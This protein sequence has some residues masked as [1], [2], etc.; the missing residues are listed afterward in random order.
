LTTIV[1]GILVVDL[2]EFNNG[3]VNW[4]KRFSNVEIMIDVELGIPD[5]LP[6]TDC[7]LVPGFV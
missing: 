3:R 1:T 2:I 5:P 7:F 4:K 6:D